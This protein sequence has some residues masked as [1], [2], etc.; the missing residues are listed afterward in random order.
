MS[1]HNYLG[2]TMRIEPPFYFLKFMQKHSKGL[3][4]VLYIDGDWKA[5]KNRIGA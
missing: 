2:G 5:A 1:C 3:F 4:E